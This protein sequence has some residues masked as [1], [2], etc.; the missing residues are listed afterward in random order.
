M[1]FLDFQLGLT[2]P[3]CK[4]VII[5][6]DGPSTSGRFLAGYCGGDPATNYPVKSTGNAVTFRFATVNDG[7]VGKGFKIRYTVLGSGK[8]MRIIILPFIDPF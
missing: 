3:L 8:Y 2:L 1:E 6:Y 4:D 7:R 5:F